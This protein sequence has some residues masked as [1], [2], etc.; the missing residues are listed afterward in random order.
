MKTIIEFED[1]PE[2][3]S[4]FRNQ[5]QD[6][7]LNQMSKE[8]GINRSTLKRWFEGSVIPSSESVKKVGEYLGI[9]ARIN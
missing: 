3:I 6:M 9:T 8:L 2:F 5:T 1:M 4:F 7:S